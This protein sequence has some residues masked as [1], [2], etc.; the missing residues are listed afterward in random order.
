MS[1]QTKGVDNSGIL[2]IGQYATSILLGN[3]GQTITNY[4]TEQFI[5][6]PNIPGPPSFP[7]NTTIAS[8]TAY[9][10]AIIP[11][12]I[13]APN[14]WPSTQTFD[15]SPRVPTQTY[16]TNSTIAASTAYVTTEVFYLYNTFHTWAGTQIFPA[17][18]NPKIGSN[19]IMN[20]ANSAAILFYSGVTTCV[21]GKSTVSLPAFTNIIGCVGTVQQ[22]NGTATCTV[23]K[24]TNS[25]TFTASG[26]TATISYTAFGT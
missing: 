23:T 12:I 24:T 3:S 6:S 14:T 19:F 7:S 21:A 5:I 8:T 1:F 25:V 13:A 22:T 11:N 10:T 2:T 4:A 26:L 9:I 20:S 15:I 17:G 18:N 16:P